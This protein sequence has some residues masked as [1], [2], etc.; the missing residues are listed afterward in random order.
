MHDNVQFHW[1]MPTVHNGHKKWWHR[2]HFQREAE[3]HYTA[4]VSNWCK[5]V[6][7]LH[8][9]GF[10]E[11]PNFKRFSIADYGQWST[12]EGDLQCML[13]I[14]DQILF[15]LWNRENG[16]E[17]STPVPEDATHNGNL[18]PLRPVDVIKTANCFPFFVNRRQFQS[19][20]L[21]LKL[22]TKTTMAIRMWNS[23]R[24]YLLRKRKMAKVAA[25]LTES[26][27]LESVPW[28][29]IVPMTNGKV[30]V[31]QWKMVIVN[32]WWR[33]APQRWLDVNQCQHRHR[34]QHQRPIAS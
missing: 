5:F 14:G 9:G 23:C 25:A 30:Q 27:R 24:W 34:Y 16:P 33:P 21:R 32:L 2:L 22:E 13:R 15:S 17:K 31:L 6:R 7:A 26:I 20:R 12:V 4:I 10:D 28:T 3:Q 18:G 1:H 19:Q 11:L 8:V 29:Q